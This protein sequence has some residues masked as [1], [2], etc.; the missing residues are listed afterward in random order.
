MQCPHCQA[1]LTEK[2][3][4]CGNCG[5]P[6]AAPAKATA[7]LPSAAIATPPGPAS[8]W[9]M[10]PWAWLVLGLAFAGLLGAGALWLSGAFNPPRPQLSAAQEEELRKTVLDDLPEHGDG[11]NLEAATNPT[12]LP[13]DLQKK[14]DQSALSQEHRKQVKEALDA[15][16]KPGGE[17]DLVDTTGTPT[18][19]DDFSNPDSGWKVATNEKAIR[20]YKDGAL[21]ITYL[22]ERGSA[23]IMAGR[24]FKDF[25]VQ[26]DATPLP[27]PANYSYG[28]VVRQPDPE[29][30]LAFVVTSSGKY[31]ISKRAN[32][33]TAPITKGTLPKSFATSPGKTNTIKV[34]CV[35]KYFALT[36]NDELVD[37]SEID[38]PP[39]GDVGVIAVRSKNEE[40]EPTRVRFDNFKL[41]TRR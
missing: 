13:E 19:S 11:I 30:F 16:P 38:A 25:A 7:A 40:T 24:S 34:S 6:V 2:D 14:F 28:L 41:W 3:R 12:D 10:P 29:T 26:I 8:T 37:I 39:E 1:A 31:F 33:T 36:V 22:R 18:L 15:L 5:Q 17:A 32:G 23:Q 35:D 27:G 9:S 20:E 4:F 21:Q